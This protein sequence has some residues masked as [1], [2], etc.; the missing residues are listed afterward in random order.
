VTPRYTFDVAIVG[1]G[2]SGTLLAIQLLRKAPPGWRRLLL[3]DRTGDFARGLAYRTREESHVLNVPAARMS[4]LPDDEGHFLEWLKRRHPG[5]GPDTYAVRRLYGDYLA[6]LLAGAERVAPNLKLVRRK[7]E[8]RALEETDTGIRLRFK[9]GPDAVGRFAVL[10][11]GNPQPAR[12]PVSR[13]ASA[14]VR[15]L[16]WPQGAA[17]PAKRASVLLVGAGLTAVD[18]VMALDARGHVGPVHVL[19]RHGLL[20]NAHPPVSVRP[21]KLEHLPLGQIRPLVHAL[22]V[23][24]EGLDW[25]AA[26]DGLR[27]LAEKVWHALGE[28]ERLRFGR[29][30]RTRWEV[31]RHRLAP[32]VAARVQG[33][34]ASGQLHLHAGHLLAIGKRGRGLEARYRT[35]GET[36]VRR[37]GVDFVVNCTGPAGHTNQPDKLVSTLLREGRG[38]PGPLGLGLATS[39]AGALLDA[40]GRASKRLWTLG[41]VR[42]GDAWESTAV[43]DIRLQVAALVEQLVRAP[44]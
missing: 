18:W 27:P 19:S 32:D 31:L 17:W 38:R 21:L 10:A 5:S 11:L 16:P 34:R 7:A 4:A 35:R 26:V 22:R 36:E 1:G 15:Q 14:R 43:P 23:A 40:R 2:A 12:L 42:R 39:I 24:A 28:A 29:H 8:V 30:V 44:R 3:V 37:L 41:P 20:P 13:A 9:K 25:R 6:E 33:L